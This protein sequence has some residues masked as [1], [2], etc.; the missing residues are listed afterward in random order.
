MSRAFE[1]ELIEALEAD[2]DIHLLAP[3]YV[4]WDV[5][6]DD[7]VLDGRFTI[8]E[9]RAIIKRVEAERERESKPPRLD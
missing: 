7:I 5:G 3:E 6:D 4:S 9:L 2:G 8:K 1:S